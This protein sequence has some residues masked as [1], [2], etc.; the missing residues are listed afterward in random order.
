MSEEKFC[1]KCEQKL[2]KPSLFNMF[3]KGKK[4]YIFKDGHYCETCAILKVEKARK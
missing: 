2:P 3:L 4:V 1:E